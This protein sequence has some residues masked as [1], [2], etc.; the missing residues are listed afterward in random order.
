MIQTKRRKE[1]I[2]GSTYSLPI[3]SLTEEEFS[4]ELKKLTLQAKV[5]F[6][7]PPPPLKAYFV[8]NDRLH[9]PRFYGLERFGE[10]EVDER[11]EGDTINIEFSGT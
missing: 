1:S 2:L 7:A 4:D 8:E 9:V 10:A 5:G 3:S 6:G 11:S